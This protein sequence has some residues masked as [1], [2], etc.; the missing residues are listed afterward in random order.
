MVRFVGTGVGV[1]SVVTTALFP[2]S[3][4]KT[5]LMALDGGVESRAAKGRG[6]GESML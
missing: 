4:L 6:G 3:V 5:R 2:L 1:F